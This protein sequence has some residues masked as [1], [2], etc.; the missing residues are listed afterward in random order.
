MNDEWIAL[1]LSTS[2][3]VGSRWQLKLRGNT[4]T[5]PLHEDSKRG[6]HENYQGNGRVRDGLVDNVPAD[7]MMMDDV[8]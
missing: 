1:H 8:V 5:F 2:M 6:G 4:A 7:R 3:L